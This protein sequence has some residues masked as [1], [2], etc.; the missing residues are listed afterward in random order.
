MASFTSKYKAALVLLKNQISEINRVS[1]DTQWLHFQ[2]LPPTFQTLGIFRPAPV[3]SLQFVLPQPQGPP[4]TPSCFRALDLI[5]PTWSVS[6]CFLQAPTLISLKGLPQCHLTRDF[7]NHHSPLIFYLYFP[8]Q[9][10]FPINI[11][12]LCPHSVS[13]TLKVS[14]WRAGDVPV[15]PG[16]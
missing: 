10:F 4:C 6:L 1:N 13:P 9:H 11:L 5:L 12:C 16:A 7:P 3:I 15:H 14:F 2:W 8:S